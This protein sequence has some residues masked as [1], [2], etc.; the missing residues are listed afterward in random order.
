MA[1]EMVPVPP[2]TPRRRHG[3][4][5]HIGLEPLVEEA[6]RAHRHQLQLVVLVLPGELPEAAQQ[7]QQLLQA[8]R[9]ERHRIGRRQAENRPYEAP[10]LHHRPA[11]FVV[12]F[13]VQARVARDLAV[14]LGVIVGPPEVVALRHRR[15]RAVERQDLEPVARE[16]ELA[17][18][19]RP[20]QRDDVRAHRE[21][22]ALEHFL[23]DGRA[24]DD[25]AAFEHQDPAAGA[26]EVGGCGEAVVPRADDGDVVLHAECI[27][28][29]WLRAS[30]FRKYAGE[31][32]VRRSSVAP[33]AVKS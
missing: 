32:G 10:H 9:V 23:G 3:G 29:S 27:V 31:L 5:E 8:P 12:G 1:F 17:D 16:I 6:G 11:V 20:E 26:G 24:A 18:D 21:V 4:L 30:G 7:E 19:L 28:T 22:K 33:L 25:V 2:R 13:G 14:G 15:E